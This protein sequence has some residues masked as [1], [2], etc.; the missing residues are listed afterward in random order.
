MKHETKNM[1]KQNIRNSNAYLG[2]SE[3]FRRD[4]HTAIYQPNW[5]AGL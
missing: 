4:F 2:R 3:T 5:G 1:Q